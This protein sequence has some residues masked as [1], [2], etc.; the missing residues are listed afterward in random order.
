VREILF[1]TLFILLLDTSQTR[2]GCHSHWD[3]FENFKSFYCVR[4]THLVYDPVLPYQPCP[5]G[6]GC[7]PP[8]RQYA[9][10]FWIETWPSTLD[11]TVKE[12]ISSF[13]HAAKAA[14]GEYTASIAPG[15]I[16]EP[17]KICRSN[18]FK[19]SPVLGRPY[20]EDVEYCI[21]LVDDDPAR[22][23][24]PWARVFRLRAEVNANVT[25]NPSSPYRV[26]E[27]SELASYEPILEKINSGVRL[28]ITE[29]LKPR[30]RV[31]ARGPYG[32][33]VH[34]TDHPR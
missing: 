5:R 15:W 28:G 30:F 29:S 10:A 2:A 8:Q 34:D 23:Q 6:V 31:D 21:H 4:S 25:K 26:P 20:F 13:Q 12:F 11:Q 1:S 27:P 18:R 33:A 19:P 14:L 22:S 9:A 16:D 24:W 3:A 17:G 32:F 7:A